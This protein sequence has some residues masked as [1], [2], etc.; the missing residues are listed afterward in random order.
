MQVTEPNDGIQQHIPH[1][2]PVW[3]LRARHPL[4]QRPV[5]VPRHLQVKGVILSF[6]ALEKSLNFDDC[7]VPLLVNDGRLL[8]ACFQ[9]VWLRAI[10]LLDGKGFILLPHSPDRVVR[11]RLDLFNLV[12]HVQLQ[13]WSPKP[14]ELRWQTASYEKSDL[15]EFLL[16][17]TS[18]FQGCILHSK[19]RLLNVVA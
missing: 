18:E 10:V 17:L 1:F 11:L 19:I 3:D 4:V 15:R 5:F 8:Q 14:C 9:M 12:K 6:G 16:D 2:A 7:R 13:R